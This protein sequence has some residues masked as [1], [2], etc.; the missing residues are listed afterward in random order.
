MKN[1]ETEMKN[2]KTEVEQFN[3]KIDILGMKFEAS[4]KELAHSFEASQKELAHSLQLSLKDYVH[5]QQKQFAIFY[6]RAFFGV[7]LILHIIHQFLTRSRSWGSQ[8]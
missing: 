7:S 2:V 8:R 5:D 3:H 1:V 4:Q 6:A